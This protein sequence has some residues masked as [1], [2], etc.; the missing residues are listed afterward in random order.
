[1]KAQAPFAPR[2]WRF[3]LFAAAAVTISIL[4]ARDSTPV[5]ANHTEVYFTNKSN[6]AIVTQ[7]IVYPNGPA[8]NVGVWVKLAHDP[9][10]VGAFEVDGTWATGGLFS[11]NAITQSTT[12]LGSTGRSVTCST[13]IVAQVPTDPTRWHANV[14]CNTFGPAPPNG[15][16]GQGKIAT[17]AISGGSQLGTATLGNASLLLNPGHTLDTNGDTIPDTVV[18]P[19]TIPALLRTVTIRVAKCGDFNADN[20]VN[21]Q[22]IFLDVLRFGQTPS[23]PGWNPMFDVDG[24]NNVG[25][26]D[27]SIVAQEFGTF[28]T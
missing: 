27:I 3:A 28:C 10:G 17:L 19:T 9:R 1:M 5:S 11:A 12:W 7:V 23:S 14:S 16:S 13:P 8:A 2:L 4:L 24:S 22:D 15:P 25:A 20:V 18:E 26:P 21:S 6:G